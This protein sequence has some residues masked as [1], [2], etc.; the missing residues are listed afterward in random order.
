MSVLKDIH[1]A[2]FDRLEAAT[3]TGIQGISWPNVTYN[4]DKPYLRINILPSPTKALGIRSTDI[5]EGFVQIDVVTKDGIGGINAVDIAE[6]IVALFP[7]NFH[8]EQGTSEIGFLEEGYPGPAIQ[9]VDGYFIPVSIPY[10]VIK[11]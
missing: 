3:I 9:E 8:A 6:E 7:R 1:V 11:R 2:V 10:I 4:G 5:Y